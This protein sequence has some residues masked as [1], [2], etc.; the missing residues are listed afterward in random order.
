MVAKQA[1]ARFVDHQIETFTWIRSIANDVAEAENLV[2]ALRPNIGKNRLEGFQVAMN[3]ANDGPFQF[4]ARFGEWMLG[5]RRKTSR[6][7]LGRIL[8]IR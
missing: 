6:P 2:D 8:V 3:I 7:F 4:T 5:E 1:H